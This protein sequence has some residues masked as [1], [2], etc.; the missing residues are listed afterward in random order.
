MLIRSSQKQKQEKKRKENPQT[1]P[2][3]DQPQQ[4]RSWGVLSA[5]R[6][7][8]ASHSPALP[9]TALFPLRKYRRWDGEASETHTPPGATS[10]G[11]IPPHPSFP[12]ATASPIRK[13]SGHGPRGER[14]LHGS[15][16]LRHVQR[17]CSRAGSDEAQPLL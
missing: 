4:S 8:A 9:S 2:P 6:H 16:S 17:G 13:A 14:F 11:S 15:F 5:P 3:P 12:A 7:A 10:H 1:H